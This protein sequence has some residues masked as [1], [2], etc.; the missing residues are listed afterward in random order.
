MSFESIPH[1][2][3]KRAQTM[4]NQ[5]AYLE[6]KNDAWVGTNWAT[7]AEQV[8]ETAKALVALGVEPGHTVCILGFN[9]SE[10]VLF[11]LA[12]MAIGA[13][14]AGIYTTCSSKE[15]QYIID[16][17]AAGV[18]LVE[19]KAQWEKIEKERK[20]LP[21][22]RH[23]VTMAG[24]ESIADD[25]VLNWSDFLANSSGVDDAVIDERLS[26]LT[27]EQ[28]ANFIYTSGTTGPPKAV[29]LTHD[30]LAWTSAA[31]VDLVQMSAEDCSVSYL[32]LSHIAEQ[33]FTLHVPISVGSMVYFAESLE[34]LPENLKEIQPTVFFGVP[35]I[36]EKFYSAVNAK[37][38]AATGVKA[39]LVAFA[40]HNASQV[41]NLRNKS[42]EPGPILNAKYR[43]GKKLV[44]DKV[45]PVLGMGRARICVSGA[46]PV[47]ADILRFFAGLDIP[48]HEVYGQSEDTGPTTFNQPGA[49]R[50]GSVGPVL[51]GSEVKIAE[52]GE[53]LVKGR[54][55]FK[56]YYKDEAAT[57]AALKDGWL[58]SGDLG[59]FDSDNYL[60]IT[61]R[62]KDIL[63]TAGGKNIAPKN[64][65]GAIKA[66]DVVGEAVVIGDR[67]KFLSA[68]VTLDADGA[69]RFASANDLSIEGLHGASALVAAIQ[70]HL[71]DSVNPQFARVEYVRK[72]TVLPEEFSIEK[73]ELTPTMKV[74]RNKVNE[75]YAEIIERMYEN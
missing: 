20:K 62:K 58:Y 73:G 61:G 75:N 8:R 29:M 11:D 33:M 52:D 26:N 67:R 3:F 18:V 37:L 55:V 14:P 23:V 45:K 66:L 47:S 59:E 40:M 74:K 49:T 39:K 53:I 9:R 44:L 17:S 21:Q 64:I 4:G 22:L 68:L 2:L 34:K 46:A 19:N 43:L 1:R 35:R 63:I 7:Y 32:P 10:W 36:W 16:H 48:I 5:T 72:F 50:Y 30:N 65:E 38:S 71:D 42:Q 24:A 51:P 57:A 60:T 13:V 54:H 56:G 69:K 15:V 25:M 6:K 31:A 12:A 70:A 27:A 41:V 28:L